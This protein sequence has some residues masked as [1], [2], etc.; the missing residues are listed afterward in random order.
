MSWIDWAVGLS[1]PNSLAIL[2]VA[3]SFVSAYGR[4]L[5][6]REESSTMGA[7]AAE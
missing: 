6:Q 1:C 3:A 5:D 2:E 7:Q 4:E